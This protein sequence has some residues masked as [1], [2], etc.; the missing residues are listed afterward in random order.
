MLARP[1]RPAQGLVGGEG[2]DVGA[3]VHGV[4]VLAPG[5]QAGDVGGVEEEQGADLVGDG[6]EGFGVDATG[7]GGGAGDDQRGVLPADHVA[8]LVEVDALV[9]AG[10]AVGHEPVETSR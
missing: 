4:L 6:P 3:V 10:D 7:V 8:H 9:G 5:H 2:H 1:A